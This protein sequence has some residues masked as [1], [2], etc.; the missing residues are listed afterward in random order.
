MRIIRGFGF[1]LIIGAVVLLV[2][3]IGW[4]VNSFMRSQ[5]RGDAQ[6]TVSWFYDDAR[7]EDFPQFVANSRDY[8]AEAERAKGEN[9]ELAFGSLDRS[10][11][12]N[13]LTGDGSL[14]PDKLVFKVDTITPQDNDGTTA[15][16]LVSGNIR[17][18]DMKRGKTSYEFSS[19]TFESF[20]HIVTL[21]K[22]GGSWYITQVEPRN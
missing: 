9:I 15:H 3:G 8:L 20:T 7:Y 14:S 1:R 21:T 11:F 6:K 22:N 10:D 13:I 4:G 17:P 2:M 16:F 19:D 5:A 12:A 18:E